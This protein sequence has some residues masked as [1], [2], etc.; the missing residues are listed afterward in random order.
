MNLKL[1]KHPLKMLFRKLGLL[2]ASNP[3]LFG[4]LSVSLNS[5]KGV[6]LVLIL[7]KICKEAFNTCKSVGI[8][9]A[10]QLK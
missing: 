8:D 4:E 5:L 3:L 1:R 7:A 10:C 9:R 6:R 2:A